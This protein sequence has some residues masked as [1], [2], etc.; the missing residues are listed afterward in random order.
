MVIGLVVLGA[1]ITV[2]LNNMQAARFQTGLLR[3]QENGRFAID[4][5]SRTMRMAGYDDPEGAASVGGQFIIGGSTSAGLQFTQSGIKSEADVIAVRYEGGVGLGP[6]A[7]ANIRDC[8]G[9]TVAAG[10]VAT[11]QYAI[12]TDADSVDHLVCI[13][14]NG[15]AV[16]L[17]EGVE[18]MR[19]RYGVDPEGDGVAN[20]YVPAENVPN[21][22]QVVS[23]EI[24]ILVNSI[25]N[26][27]KTAGNVCLGC[28][29]FAGSEDQNLRAEFQ[30]TIGVRN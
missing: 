10:T 13:T 5:M 16:P 21:W 1:V 24:S 27:L 25:E 7:N 9:N 11:N 2:Y 15:N 3:V 18:D 29:M 30:A 28:V 19:I 4:V 14:A 26:V 23:I 20:R 8:R 17:A 22:G 6:A 12:W